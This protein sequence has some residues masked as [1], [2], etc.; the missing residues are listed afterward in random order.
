[1]TELGHDALL[2]PTFTPIRTDEIDV[3]EGRV[4]YGGI[5]VFLEQKSRLFRHTPRWVDWLFNRPWLLRLATRRSVNSDYAE[6]AELTVSMLRGT[7]G[8]QRKELEKLVGWLRAEVADWPQVAFGAHQARLLL[9]DGT[10]I[11]PVAIL[12]SGDI[13]G[14]GEAGLP[15]IAKSALE[16]FAPA[17]PSLWVTRRRPKI[18]RIACPWLIRRFIDASARIYFVDPAEVARAAAYLASS[19]SGLMTGATINLDQSIWG[20]YDGSPQPVAP[21]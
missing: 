1:M 16:R 9:R 4:F 5:N 15:M 10:V 21:L 12:P 11:A 20:A 19:E 3:S 13:V 7:H 18:D 14:W 17:S 2:V 6:L 8:H